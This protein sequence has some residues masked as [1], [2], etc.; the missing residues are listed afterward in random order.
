MW[1]YARENKWM[2]EGEGIGEVYENG[3]EDSEHGDPPMSLF[4]MVRV[5]LSPE[6]R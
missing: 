1:Q 3:D 6:I 5:K 4:V 2:L